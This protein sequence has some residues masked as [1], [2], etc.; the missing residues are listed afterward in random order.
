MFGQ[1]EYG[2]GG[3]DSQVSALL[4]P[5][6]EFE[7]KLTFQD[8]VRINGHFRGEI[9]SEGTLIV[10]EGAVIDARV[11]VGSIIINGKVNGEIEAQDRIE[12]RCPAQVRGDISAR[13]LVVEE[14]VVF[15]GACRMGEPPIISQRDGDVT[16]LHAA[17]SDVSAD[18]GLGESGS[19]I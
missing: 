18:E 16:Q 10:G 12:M 1:K 2:E 13:T 6:C 7:G 3:A 11:E 19:L 4:E 15:E 17:N 14:G 5:G 8:T 9:F